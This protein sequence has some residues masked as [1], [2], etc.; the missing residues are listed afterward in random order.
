ML[1]FVASVFVYGRGEGFG[2]GAIRDAYPVG[3]ATIS[4][5]S[6]A[7]R[8]SSLDDVDFAVYV[9]E[10]IANAGSETMALINNINVD[11]LESLME[12][13]RKRSAQPR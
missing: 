2:G 4:S 7:Q 6:N 12:V 9:I 1:C 11:V 3:S 13:Y 5:A 10:K 8:L